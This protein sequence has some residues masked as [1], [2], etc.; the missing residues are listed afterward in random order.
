VDLE[1][2]TIGP[3]ELESW[4]QAVETAFGGH[5]TDDDVANERKVLEVDRTLA[6]V[7]ESQIVG[8]ASAF[9]FELTVPGGTAPAAGITGVGVRPTHRRRGVNTALMRRQLDDV[10]ERESLA[11]L[12][13]SEGSIYG[14]Y[15]YGLGALAAGLDVPTDRSG[16][17]R[18]YEPVGRVRMLERPEAIEAFVPVLARAGR[19]RP[20][21]FAI[22]ERWLDYAYS[23][24]QWGQER[25]WFFA[26]HEGADGLDG[27]AAYLVKHEWR[28]GVPR[29]RLNVETLEAT[30]PSA[31][32]DLWRFVLDTDLMRTVSAWN[33]PADE[34][35]LHLLREPR[36][37]RLRLRDGLW[38]RLVDVPAALAARRYASAGRLAFE[39]RDPFCP[40]NEGRFVLEGGPDGAECR[41]ADAEPDLVVSATELG[42]TYLGGPSFLQL[43]RA[44]RVT[45]A[46]H[47]SI[48]RADAMFGWRPAPW[49]SFMF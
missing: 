15:G 28:D 5:L 49:C 37:A 46:R 2:R 35:L 9:T 11:V 36:R 10:R 48:A 12:F 44:G 40:W 47:G 26:A 20:G 18:G 23:Q 19:D 31:Y 22:D 41:P 38:V 13:A 6:A 34:P 14:R 42:A 7:A 4:L 1:I 27:V 25:H 43:H 32:A 30:T 39:V 17:V 29:S 16:Y 3:D 24:K 33:R 8:C 21:S 45:E